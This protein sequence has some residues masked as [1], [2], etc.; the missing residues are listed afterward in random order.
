MNLN[1]F[2]SLPSI[3]V[4]T[5]AQLVEHRTENPGVPGSIPGGDTN[6]KKEL[7]KCSSF[8]YEW[9]CIMF[10]YFLAHRERNITLVKPKICQHDYRSI[11]MA[12]IRGVLPRERLIGLFFIPLNVKTERLRVK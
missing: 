11:M 1:L 12:Y 7:Q 2:L 6:N 3:K 4:V 8:F 5:L 9:Q 10:T